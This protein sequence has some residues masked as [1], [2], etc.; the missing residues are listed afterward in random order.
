M[1]IKCP[2]VIQIGTSKLQ[3]IKWIKWLIYK[4]YLRSL[5]KVRDIQLHI[6]NIGKIHGLKPK[7]ATIPQHAMSERP[8]VCASPNRTEESHLTLIRLMLLVA[9]LTKTKWCKGPEKWLN[10]PGTWTWVLID[11]SNQIELC[12][13]YKH[14]RD[15]TIFKHRCFPLLWTKVASALVG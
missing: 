2:N 5:F 13:E 4:K 14:D 7:H 11:L 10:R 9:N 3:Y 1:L 8:R 12:K 15:C 6:T